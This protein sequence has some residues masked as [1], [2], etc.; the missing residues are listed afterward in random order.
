MGSNTCVDGLANL[1]N[2]DASVELSKTAV[3]D[4][5]VA[6]CMEEELEVN[7]SQPGKPEDL[8]GLQDPNPRAT[9]IGVG[10]P[11]HIACLHTA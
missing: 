1:L 8:L 11:E 6:G 10:C 4:K 7:I 3:A 2:C 9:A 5:C